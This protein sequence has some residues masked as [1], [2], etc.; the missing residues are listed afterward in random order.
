MI[1]NLENLDEELFHAKD[2]NRFKCINMREKTIIHKKTKSSFLLM[3][4]CPFIISEFILE[5]INFI[6]Y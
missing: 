3:T 6:I 4:F 2:K 5:I 1:K